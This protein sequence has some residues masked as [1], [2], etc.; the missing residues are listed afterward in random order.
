MTVLGAPE[1]VEFFAFFVAAIQAVVPGFTGPVMDLPPLPF[2]LQ[3]PA[4]LRDVLAT[5]GLNDIRVETITEQ[6]EF[7]SGTRLWGS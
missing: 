2:E 5:A 6:L 1:R 7:R 4:R 3:E